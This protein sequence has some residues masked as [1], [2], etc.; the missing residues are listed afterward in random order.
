M[1]AAQDPDSVQT[2][3]VPSTPAPSTV[4]LPVDSSP[5]TSPATTTP[6]PIPMTTAEAT[7]AFAAAIEGSDVLTSPTPDEVAQAMDN[8]LYAPDTGQTD[9]SAAGNYV[10]LPTCR[11]TMWPMGNTSEP[12]P[13]CP[14]G[15]PAGWA[16]EA[17]TT[18]G[19]EIHH[20]LLGEAKDLG[21]VALNDRYFLAMERAPDVQVPIAWLI[22]A[23]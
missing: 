12:S 16:F 8:A 10:A 15:F 18:D 5:V 21:V 1:I 22:D 14:D 11:F 6:A 23:Q 2:D 19:A 3:T 13:R 7:T 4:L 9:V 17:G 20:G